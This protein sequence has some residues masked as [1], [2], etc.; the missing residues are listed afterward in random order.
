[1]FWVEVPVKHVIWSP[2]RPGTLDKYRR[3]LFWDLW[4]GSAP[5]V[6]GLGLGGNYIGFYIAEEQEL[7]K[8]R[9]VTNEESS[10]LVGA[11]YGASVIQGDCPDREV[12]M[13]AL[14][15]AISA[16]T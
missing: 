8:A 16:E 9:I 11:G 6:D 14:I 3:E 15:L 4:S 5:Y 12:G 1:M 10:R 2:R 7:L 13:D